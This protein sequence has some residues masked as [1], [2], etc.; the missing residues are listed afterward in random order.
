METRL[1]M[2]EEQ[3]VLSGA[4]I[5]RGGATDPWDLEARTGGLGSARVLGTV[6]EHGH[7]HQMVRWRMSPHLSPMVAL[8]AIGIF[9]LA[10]LAFL[11]GGLLAAVVLAA[12]G[13][14]VVSRIVLDIGSALAVIDGA[15]EHGPGS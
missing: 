8:G 9:V 15:I 14:A 4:A 6:E 11:G 13:V 12:V 5:Q 1:R 10:G 2:L 7:G 3:L